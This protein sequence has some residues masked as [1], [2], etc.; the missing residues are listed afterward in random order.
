M[1]E[2]LRQVW[3]FVVDASRVYSAYARLRDQMDDF[4][5]WM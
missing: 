3:R 4:K 1:I 2:R 5:D